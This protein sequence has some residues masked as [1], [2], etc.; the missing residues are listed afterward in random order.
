[1][2][3][4]EV[5]QKGYFSRSLASRIPVLLTQLLHDQVSSRT[6]LYCTGK[7]LSL[8]QPHPEGL[9]VPWRLEWGCNLEGTSLL[10]HYNVFSRLKFAILSAQGHPGGRMVTHPVCP[11]E[12]LQQVPNCWFA[13]WEAK[14]EACSIY[15]S[16]HCYACLNLAFSFGRG[17]H[18]GCLPASL[19]KDM[20]PRLASW[21]TH[22][23]VMTV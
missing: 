20:T 17:K 2:L 12:K 19:Q 8:E 9:L 14:A 3:L 15:W 13:K 1:M 23:E 21:V 5:K 10:L 4:V 11:K 22:L 7:P 18:P 6:L 16:F